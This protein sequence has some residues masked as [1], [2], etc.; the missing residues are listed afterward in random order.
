[1]EVKI[2]DFN[3]KLVQACVQA[4]HP[5]VLYFVFYWYAAKSYVSIV[6]W[7]TQL[8]LLLNNS[9]LFDL[10]SGTFSKFNN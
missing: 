5:G 2:I 7:K 1:M 3:V 10:E 4:Y 8:S 9:Y 6:T